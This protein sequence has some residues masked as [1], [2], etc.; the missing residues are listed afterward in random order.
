MLFF[1]LDALF[2]FFCLVLQGVVL[3]S[4]AVVCRR[5]RLC[6]RDRVLPSMSFS[7]L[8]RSCLSTCFGSRRGR[9]FYTSL[10]DVRRAGAAFD[11]LQFVASVVSFNMFWFTSGSCSLLV[12][13]SRRSSRCCRRG[14]SVCCLRFVF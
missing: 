13:R 6:L 8:L 1:L 4:V 11:V 7:L 9:V 12:F 10:A 2:F 5:L 3:D 14:S